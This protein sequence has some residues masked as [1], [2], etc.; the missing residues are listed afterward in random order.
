M[1]SCYRCE[2]LTKQKKTPK[3]HGVTAGHSSFL[4]KLTDLTGCIA[5]RG[6][7]RQLDLSR[8]HTKQTCRSGRLNHRHKVSFIVIPGQSL[9]AQC[10]APRMKKNWRNS[11]RSTTLRTS[12]ATVHCH[13]A[14][15]HFV[16]SS[17]PQWLGLRF[18]PFQT[19]PCFLLSRVILGFN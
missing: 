18:F 13:Y 4:M 17:A 10:L 19:L 16:S 6:R 1:R 15:G 9:V 2:P 3:R 5:W 14:V 12:K 8:C 7:R 11:W